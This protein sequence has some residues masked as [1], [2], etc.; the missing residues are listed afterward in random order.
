[1]YPSDFRQKLQSDGVVLGTGMPGTEPHI[2]AQTYA[3]GPDWVWIDNEHSPWGLE[4]LSTLLVQGRNFGVAPVVRVPWNE[5]GIIKRT[6]DAGAVGVMVP[7]VDNPEEAADAIRYAKYPPMGERGIAPWFAGL[8]GIEGSDVIDNANSETALFLQMESA[9][10]YEKLD[11]TLKLDGFEVLIV[12]PADLSGSY[13]FPGQI[14]HPKVEQ[15]MADIVDRVRA[16]GKALGTTFADP[17]DARRWVSE[18]YNVMNISS[19]MALGTVGIKRLF[20]EFREE[21]GA[22]G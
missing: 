20:A 2:A 9:E 1:M 6:Y 10:A 22:A 14:H 3:C 4:R 17:G 13:G 15:I 12:G 16:A 18:G 5:P 7:Q 19:P 8:M 21:F 11:E